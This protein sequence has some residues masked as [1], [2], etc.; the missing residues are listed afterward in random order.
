MAPGSI[1]LIDW[2]RG[3]GKFL[4]I[5]HRCGYYT[6]YAHVSEIFVNVGDD[7]VGGETI[8]TVGDT[9]SLQGPMLH[10]EI[11]EGKNEID[12]MLWLRKD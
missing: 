7:V 1:I 2:L 10:F 9:G 3:Y 5:D 12:P 4:I 8:A 6:L 11:R